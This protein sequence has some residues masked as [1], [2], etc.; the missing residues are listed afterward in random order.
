MLTSSL[1]FVFRFDFLISLS[2]FFKIFDLLSPIKEPVVT[3]EL[4]PKLELL[5]ELVCIELQK[6][7][8]NALG[9]QVTAYR[10]PAAEQVNRI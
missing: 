1:G 2:D 10:V 4:A 5:I 9:F 3:R 7:G 8:F 6:S